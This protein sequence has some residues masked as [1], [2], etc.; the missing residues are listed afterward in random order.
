MM[1]AAAGR[2]PAAGEGVEHAEPER[3]PGRGRDVIAPGRAIERR[4]DGATKGQIDELVTAAGAV[5]GRLADGGAAGSAGL[6]G[7]PVAGG[8][9]GLTGRKVVGSGLLL[10]VV[11]VAFAVLLVSVA[12]LRTATR[13]AR[14]S[15][16]VLVA[17]NQLERLAIDLETGQRGFV[18]T[19]QERFLGP[20]RAARVAVPGQASTL[21]RLVAG[22]PAQQRRAQRLWRA[23][24][25]YVEDYSVGLVAAARRDPAAARTVAA[26]Q[27]GKRRV[28]AMRG[29]F[30]RLIGTE[31][32]L[33]VARQQR[34]QGAARRAIGAAAG[35]LA[36]SVLLIGGLAGYLT[37]AIVRPVRST[38]AVAGRLA[39]GD[40]GARM[41]QR[42]AGE[43]GGLQ[44]SF[45]TMAGSLQA[46]RAELGRLADEQAALRRVATLV[47]RGV[48]AAEVFA[49]LAQEAGRLLGADAAHVL[50]YEHDA[51]VTLVAGWSRDGQALPVGT[52]SPIEEE[53]LSALMLRTGQPARTDS[54]ADHPG[55]IGTRI[56]QLGIRSSVACPITVQGRLWGATAV[57]STQPQPLPPDTQAR[58]A[59]AASRARIV[60]AADQTRRRIER[61][62]HDGIQQRLVSLA[63]DL[64]ATQAS[65]PAQLGELHA[66]LDRVAD[67]LSQALEELRETSRGIHPAALSQGGLGPALKVLARRCPLPV[68]ADLKLQ[69]RLPEPVEV[70]AYYVVAEALTN[71][72]K[73]AHASLAHLAVQ[74]HHDRL[75][76]SVAD[77]GVG[78]ADPPRGSGLVGLSDRVQALG[79][80]ITVHSPTGQGTTLQIA[81]PTG[82]DGD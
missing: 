6:V 43:I 65:L 80:T 26:T 19:G 2:R 82:H 78:G 46:S 5:V 7:G 54:H 39:G 71:A 74:A 24:R 57:S 31:Q 23:V 38:A 13:L 76:L 56:R 9:V 64:R 25:S 8:K 15:Q 70:A 67:G 36:G 11:G 10:V 69:T 53:T 41:P 73:H 14:H 17:A 3:G 48:P 34:A 61:D 60:K 4:M 28:D 1:A 18:I 75:H 52:R 63:L 77:D 40:L 22:D 79:G 37:R 62:L 49:A 51:T 72:A 81:L 29:E 21:A 12:E 47:A 50:R 58:I 42:R 16:E 20:W 32:G 30:D 33:A 66:Q 35:G 45:N 44:R 68:Q 27:E 59:L 55:A